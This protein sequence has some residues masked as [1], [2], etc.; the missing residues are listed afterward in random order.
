PRICASDLPT[1]IVSV[2]N[3]PRFDSAR[4]GVLIQPPKRINPRCTVN[5]PDTS[6]IPASNIKLLTTAAALRIVENRAPQALTSLESWLTVVNRDSHNATADELLRR[7]G[8]Q[9]AVRQVLLPLGIDPQGYEQVDGSGLSRQNRANPSTFVALLKSMYANDTSGL[10]YRSLPIAGV[11]GTLRNRFRDTPVQGKLYA[12]TGTL[13][14]VRAL[15]GYLENEDY[16]II[17]FSIMVNQSAQS[18]QTLVQALDQIVLQMAQVER[19]E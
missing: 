16:G 15:S 18:G 19:C 11:S 12:K 3:N 4:W 2:I 9:Q 6:L 7:I 13:Q 5:N 10:F 17:T 14:G 1:A 8:G